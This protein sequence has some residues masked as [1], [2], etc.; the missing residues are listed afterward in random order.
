MAFIANTAKRIR[1]FFSREPDRVQ[2]DLAK[3]STMA[4]ALAGGDL[5]QIFGYDAISQYLKLEND[6]ITRYADYEDMEESS[7]ISEALDIFADDATQQN[8]EMR[9]TVW[10]SCEDKTIEDELNSLFRDRLRM[11]EN[12]AWE[13]A[14][15]MCKYGSCFEEILVSHEGVVGLNH[16]PT[17][18]VRRVENRRGHLLGFIQDP[19]GKFGSQAARFMAELAR[20]NETIK[21][22]GK[23]PEI[24]NKAPRDS[25]QVIPFEHWEL[26]H[27]RLCGARRRSTYG[28]SI[29]EAARWIYKRLSLLEDAA[30]IYRLQRAPERFAFYVD[31]GDL[32]PAEA[33]AYLNRVR[34]NHRKKRYSDP[35]TGKLKLK[36][37]PIDQ[38][39]DIFI[40]TRKGQDGARVEV[41]GAPAWQHMD[42]IEYFKSNLWSALKVPKAYMGDSSGTARATLSSQDVRFARV[43]LRVQNALRDGF[44]RIARVHLS[45]I[46]VDP[47]AVRFEVHMTVPSAIYELAQLEVRNARADLAS[48]MQDFVSKRWVLR[49]VF[50]MEEAEIEQIMEERKQEAEEE[51][52]QAA[53]AAELMPQPGAPPGAE[54][55]SKPSSSTGRATSA[56]AAKPNATESQVNRR[57]HYRYGSGISRQGPILAS[58]SFEKETG[59]KIETLLKNDKFMAARLSE[60]GHFLQ[61]IRQVSGARR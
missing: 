26:A 34:Q 51:A 40:P 9:R 41:L 19:R 22:P 17:P 58:H 5:F 14:R 37:D 18:T 43:I 44:A 2:G 21:A 55:M 36:L 52:A 30:L 8:T 45:A 35:A 6:L 32:P 13:I 15:V 47:S 46:G 61:E 12:D 60:I 57:L 38:Q 10:I 1:S 31:V 29:L 33:L 48:R 4:P 59:Q 16:L 20:R 27:F 54:S 53:A 23:P 11:D 42:D 39:E 56:S 24:K 49:E 25:Q 28:E 7:L 50:K 3:G